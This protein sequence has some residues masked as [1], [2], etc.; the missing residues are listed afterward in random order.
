MFDRTFNFALANNGGPAVDQASLALPDTDR[1]RFYLEAW[2]SNFGSSNVHIFEG[3]LS[4]AQCQGQMETGFTSLI[5]TVSGSTIS[6][7]RL[8]DDVN[9]ITVFFEVVN[10]SGQFQICTVR[11][12]E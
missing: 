9:E 6:R 7:V 12:C 11:V 5:M 1:H 8:P 3:K 10:T 4:V 2:I